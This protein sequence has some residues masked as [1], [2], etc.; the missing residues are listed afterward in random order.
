MREFERE[1]TYKEKQRI[2]K[3]VSECAN[4]CQEYGCLQLNDAC[5]MLTKCWTGSYCSYFREAVLPL[6]PKL[7]ASLT[8]SGETKTCIIC[9][10]EFPA[11]SKRLYCSD[12]CADEVKKKQQ[13]KYMRKRRGIC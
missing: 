2:K 8:G 9:G 4:Y 3:L 7:E 12:A 5:Y 6:D 13:R 10:Y 1:L 11:G